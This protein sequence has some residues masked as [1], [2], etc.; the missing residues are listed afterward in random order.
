MNQEIKQKWLEAL[1]SGRYKQGTG[2]LRR[3]KE[4]YCCLGV[5]CDVVS[6]V[7][8]DREML[9]SHYYYSYDS[10]YETTDLPPALKTLVCITE[11]DAAH[12]ISMNDSKGYTFDQIADW[13]EANL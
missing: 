1:R 8:W 6:P 12:L 5:L 3:V 9:N 7:G 11:D 13:I 10:E 4:E 2:V